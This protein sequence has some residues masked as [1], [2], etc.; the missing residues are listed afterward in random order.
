MRRLVRRFASHGVLTP[1]DYYMNGAHVS[2][3]Q[4]YSEEAYRSL[5]RSNQ[6]WAEQNAVSGIG[7]ISLIQSNSKL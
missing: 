5:L 2:S 7:L 6:L 3:V 4:R 1:N